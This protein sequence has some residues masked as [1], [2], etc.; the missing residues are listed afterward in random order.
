MRNELVMDQ[1]IPFDNHIKSEVRKWWT[2]L[3]HKQITP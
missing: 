2:N 3:F 1:L